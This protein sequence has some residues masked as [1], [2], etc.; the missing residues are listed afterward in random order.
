MEFSTTSTSYA[1]A[2]AQDL[3]PI[4]SPIAP[5]HTFLTMEMKTSNAASTCQVLTVPV[6]RLKEIE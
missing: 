4:P 5:G 1:T 2:T 3:L 6:L